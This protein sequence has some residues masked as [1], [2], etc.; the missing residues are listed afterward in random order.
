MRPQQIARGFAG[1]LGLG[2]AFALPA[3]S[4]VVFSEIEP[5]HEYRFMTDRTYVD[6]KGETHPL[7]EVR[8]PAKGNIYLHVTADVA[9]PS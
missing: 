7:Y 8:K 5:L 6:E 1:A 3:H 2:M 4:T 9:T